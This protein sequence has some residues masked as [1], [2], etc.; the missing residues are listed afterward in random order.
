MRLAFWKKGGEDKPGKNGY[1]EISSTVLLIVSAP[2][3]AIF[4]TS[5]VFQSYEVDGL[6]METTLQN[7]DRLIVNKLSK[8]IANI[9]GN[10]Y[11]PNRYDV[12]VFDRPAN[13]NIGK[14]VDHLIKRV[15]AL[16]GERVVVSE[17]TV[18][19]YNKDA[20]DGFNPDQDQ[21]YQ[22]GISTTPGRVDIT[23]GNGEVFV[24]G[25]NRT[26]STDSRRFGALSTDGV[27][28]TASYRFIPVNNMKR[29]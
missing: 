2:L 12:I 4:L 3:L 25:D 16:P 28:G 20:P 21:D 19:V 14:S 18:T 11:M 26:N 15:I 8:T 27:V 9:S 22:A 13:A 6:S 24:L 1:R 5:H 29:L 23:V 10:T 17:G 7:G